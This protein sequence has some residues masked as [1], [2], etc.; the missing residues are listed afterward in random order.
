MRHA[1]AVIPRVF[2][3]ADAAGRLPLTDVTSCPSMTERSAHNNRDLKIHTVFFNHLSYA[4]YLIESHNTATNRIAQHS[5]RIRECFPPKGKSSKTQQFSK[6]LT[7]SSMSQFPT[8]T[9]SYFKIVPDHTPIKRTK[10]N[11]NTR[12]DE[13]S[14]DDQST[15]TNY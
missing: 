8:S 11:R 13:K 10:T 1:D 14:W 6:C 9:R 15:P 2:W 5:D 7:T 4:K 12:G 3:H